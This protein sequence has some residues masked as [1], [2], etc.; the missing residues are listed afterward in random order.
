MTTAP[1]SRPATGWLPE[2]LKPLFSGWSNI[3]ITTACAAL[4]FWLAA[5]LYAWGWAEAV[6]RGDAAVCRAA[7][8][9]CW[10]FVA[11]KLDFFIFGFVPEAAHWRV[12]LVLCLIAA[13]IGASLYRAFWGRTLLAT[14]VVVLVFAAL[15]LQGGAFGL[16]PAPLRTWSG[17]VVTVWIAVVALATAYPL[18]LILALG[19]LSQMR[20]VRLFSIAWIELVRGVPLIS[21]L[22]L[23]S[24]MVPLFLPE[25][26][27]LE[28]L[29][30]AQVGFTIF[31]SAYLAEIFRAGL[32]SVPKGQS[33]G[34]ASL[35]LTHWQAL[36]LVVLPQALK[37]VIPA[38]VNTFIM[39]FKDTSLVLVIGVF[40][41]LGTFKASLSDP[42]W[43]GFS[44][45]AYV[46]G[47]V[48]YF[49][50]CFGMSLYSRHLEG[51]LSRG[52]QT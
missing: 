42:A 18:G 5:K 35:A 11:D 37:A 25:G 50:V 29:V 36:R 10:A 23:A 38:Q 1:L 32:Q 3:V 28:V 40:D 20:V 26:V 14:W 34:A 19:R 31:G 43:L 33:E 45:E 2:G 47:A 48:F 49:L 7:S 8:G 21:I 24:I 13:M 27:E 44:T 41:L 22:F 6:F 12:V 4:T 51:A 17:L 30:R 9:A 39:I 15:F 52:H 16:T 46:A